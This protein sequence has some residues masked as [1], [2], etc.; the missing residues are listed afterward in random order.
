MVEI[1]EKYLLQTNL[2]LSG[3]LVLF[4]QLW[5]SLR[6]M[7]EPE[8]NNSEMKSKVRIGDWIILED[9]EWKIAEITDEIVTLYREG[10]S[11]NSHT[12]KKSL[13]DIESI[14]KQ[15]NDFS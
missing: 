5:A 3:V 12:I 1:K 15:Q 2:I 6:V 4:V 9:L 10:V 11:G 7:L 8:N 13:I 14:L